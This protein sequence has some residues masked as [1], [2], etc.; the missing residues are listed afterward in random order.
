ME[1]S[2]NV[3]NARKRRGRPKAEEAASAKKL[4]LDALQLG[5]RHDRGTGHVLTVGQGDTG[6]LGL[7]E[8]ILEKSRPGLVADIKDAVDVVAGGMHTIVLTKNGE[9][10]SFG[11]NDEGALG[12][13]VEEEE[14][15]FVPGKVELEGRVVQLS[16][17]DSHTAVITDAGKLFAWGTFRDSSGPIGLTTGGGQENTPIQLLVD[18]LVTKVASGA[19]HIAALTADGHIFT[20]GN[21]EQGQLGRIP[22][23]FAHRG[24]R[25]GL[26]YLLTPDK[27]RAKTRSTVFEDVWAGSYNT[28]ARTKKKEI[29]VM[30]LNNYCQMGMETGQG[31]TFFMPTRSASLTECGMGSLS[32]GLHHALV[33]TGAGGVAAL[34]RS[35][36]GRLGLG[37]TEGDAK[38]PTGIPT[39]KSETCV[40]IACGSAVSYAVTDNGTCYAWG[41]GTN[42]QLCTG[43]DEDL[44]VP[45]VVKSKQLENRSVIAVSSGGQHTVLLAKDK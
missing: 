33:L 45:T 32:L 30:G 6:Q 22:E 38:V 44:N 18:H 12:R 24:G 20:F 41:M 27:V 23:R 7:G 25:R 16:A 9:V 19:A 43:E 21:A 29:V 35:D 17:G 42:G 1:D 40:E 2:P 31:I 8:D 4:R 36:Y 15:C 14:D 11:C 37:E 3:G 13:K 28:I 10:Y 39:L 26:N 5:F 34:G